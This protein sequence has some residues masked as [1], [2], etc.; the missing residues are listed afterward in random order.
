MLS[1]HIDQGVNFISKLAKKYQTS[2][3]G[4]IDFWCT[5]VAF[6]PTVRCERVRLA[7]KL[8]MWMLGRSWQKDI[9]NTPRIY[10]ISIVNEI[11]G[12]DIWR[13]TL[14]WSKISTNK[15]TNDKLAI[16]W[17]RCQY[18]KMHVPGRMTSSRQNRVGVH[19]VLPGTRQY[20]NDCMF[21]KRKKTQTKKDKRQKEWKK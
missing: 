2:K 16:G 20:E 13:Q 5:L 1:V 8:T 3:V 18:F 11:A 17:S 10:P 6:W 14:A 9:N 21:Q 19:V 15:H 7:E 4:K 12:Y